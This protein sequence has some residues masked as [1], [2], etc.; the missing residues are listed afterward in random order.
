M[1]YLDQFKKHIKNQDY[2][3]FFSLW[4]EYCL[5]DDVD[6][7]ELKCILK[8]VKNSQ[9]ALPF[10]RHV[11][12]A[13]D[14]WEQIPQS[15]LK[16]EV[17]KL[18]LDI[19]TTNMPFL[20][21]LTLN[22]LKTRYREDIYYDDKIRLIGLKEGDDFQGAISNYE[23]LTHMKKGHFVFH[24]GGWGIGEICEISF[25]REQLAIEFDYVSGKKELSFQNAFKMLVPI[26]EEH[27]LA[28]RFGNP[29]AL[30]E[31]ARKNSVEV[32]HMLLR[33]L[34]PSTTAEIKE[35][36]CDLVIPKKEWARWWQATRSK[37]KKDTLIEVP[38][39]IR[40]PLTLR[41]TEIS[42]EDRLQKAIKQKPDAN[43]LIQM[44]YAF[45]RDYP[46][47]L[48]NISFKNQLQEYIEMA[49]SVKELTDA[50]ELQL[51]FILEDLQIE[52]NN[53]QELIKRFSSFEDVMKAIEVIAFK[54]RLL[55]A[56]HA[57]RDDWS[58]IFSDL[59]LKVEQNAIRDY[60]FE[61][62]L[63]SKK[64]ENVREKLDELLAFP[65][66]SPQVFLW[67]FRKIMRDSSLPYSD[68]E[69]KNRFF[70]SFFILLS[71]LEQRPE[72]REFVKKMLSFL[73]KGRYNNVRKI[74]QNASIS[75]VQ[76]LLLL[77]TKCHSLNNHDI[78]IF[79]SL[80]EVVHPSL[81]KLGGKYHTTKDVE[82]HTIWTTE[83]GYQKIKERI[84]HISTVEIVE[85]AKEIEMA[86][87]HGDL[88][89]NA[90]FKAALEKRS[91]LQRELQMLSGQFNKARII[92]KDDISTDEVSVGV[93]IDCQSEDGDRLSYTV[94]GPWE[95]DPECYI[96]SFQSKLAQ[97]LTGHKVGDTVV[98][99]GKNMKILNLRNYFESE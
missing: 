1:H 81:A 99:Q 33:D 8:N 83:K 2:T 42:H 61:Q 97:S 77:A 72:Y 64:E 36:L 17:I 56:I 53:S 60:V 76:E 66:R 65:Y 75:V 96:F 4:E 43:T 7:E 98:V 47:T 71:A 51:Y 49:L 15:A 3:A 90:E 52:S 55:V 59:L 25:L 11:E 58:E 20:A 39:D 86:R 28:Q 87:A 18:I 40:K 78:K 73:T 27:F 57:L 14:L 12:K 50:Q 45:L 10:G 29:D 79:H 35:E 41:K 9:I 46:Q 92:N 80:A 48:K 70:E 88:R 21:N 32:I 54:K 5:G 26:S 82:D 93:V 69:G 6:G 31:H 94:L 19:Q 30:E 85:N 44:V 37:I 89:E 23:L 95:A 22:Y 63:N 74:F 38:K 34:G 67:Y 16:H 24:V 68:Q 13:L 62:L 91:Q 84:R